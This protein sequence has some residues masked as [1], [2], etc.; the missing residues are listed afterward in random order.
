MIEALRNGTRLHCSGGRSILLL[1]EINRGGNAITY[2]AQ[3]IRIDG[4]PDPRSF[5]VKEAVPADADRFMRSDFEVVPTTK[6]D[7]DANNLLRLHR[8]ALIKEQNTGSALANVSSRVY[9]LWERLPLE[10][11]S[12]GKEKREITLKEQDR[13]VFGKID[14]LE[15]K[16]T[17]LSSIMRDQLS[18]YQTA[19]LIQK[20]LEALSDCH[21][22]HVLHGDVSPGNVFFETK[23]NPKA[24]FGEAYLT[25]FATA[26]HVNESG[27]TAPILCPSSTRRYAA[28]EFYT[29][30]PELSLSFDVYSVAALWMDMLG[31]LPDHR[32]IDTDLYLFVRSSL[33]EKIIALGGTRACI[34]IT[35]EILKKALQL[36]CSERYQTA[37]E[38]LEPVNALVDLLTPPTFKLPRNLAIS[39]NWVKGSRRQDLKALHAALDDGQNPVY[40]WG[41]GGLGKSELARKL[42]QEREERNNTPAYLI[43]YKGSMRFTIQT[44][45]LEGYSPNGKTEDEVAQEK[46]EL[47][48]KYYSHALFILDNYEVDDRIVDA[49]SDTELQKKATEEN[50]LFQQFLGSVGRVVITTRSRPTEGDFPELKELT[51]DELLKLFRSIAKNEKA[52]DEKILELIRAV[53]CHPLTVELMAAT[54]H[55]SWSP[56]S[57]SDL[58]EKGV[59]KD[60]SYPA[61]VSNKDRQDKKDR[62]SGHLKALFQLANLNEVQKRV[63]CQ[64]SLLPEGGMDAAL[65]WNCETEEEQD[66]LETLEAH[67]WLRR[68]DGLL[69]IHSLVREVVCAELNP[70]ESQCMPFL[71]CLWN[72]FQ[73]DG[74]KS[75]DKWR[76]TIQVFINAHKMFIA[77][78]ADS[79]NAYRAANIMFSCSERFNEAQALAE[80]AAAR[81]EDNGNL[82]DAADAYRLSSVLFDGLGQR[83][84]AIISA[85]RAYEIDCFKRVTVNLDDLCEDYHLLDI[86]SEQ[87]TKE[88][89]SACKAALLVSAIALYRAIP[90]LEEYLRI[91]NQLERIY[92]DPND[93][94]TV[95]PLLLNWRH[96]STIISL[97]DLLT[98]LLKLD[99]TKKGK[100]MSFSKLSFYTCLRILEYIS[101]HVNDITNAEVIKK[102]DRFLRSIHNTFC[103][104]HDDLACGYYTRIVKIRQSLF[105]DRSC[106]IELTNLG[107]EWGRIALIANSEAERKE[108]LQKHQFYALQGLKEA[109][110]KAPDEMVYPL[111]ALAN[112]SLELWAQTTDHADSDELEQL[113]AKAERYAL[114]AIDACRN[115]PNEPPSIEQMRKRFFEAGITLSERADPI[116][117]EEDEIKVLFDINDTGRDWFVK[118]VKKRMEYEKEKVLMDYSRTLMSWRV[119]EY[120]SLAPNNPDETHSTLSRLDD[121]SN[122]AIRAKRRIYEKRFIHE[123]RRIEAQSVSDDLLPYHIDH[124]N[125]RKIKWNAIRCKYCR[126]TLESSGGYATH[127]LKTC[128]CGAVGIDGGEFALIRFTRSGSAD[129]YEELSVLEP[130]EDSSNPNYEQ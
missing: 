106:A 8:D 33:S 61:V 87:G 72:A 127:G 101:I 26:K 19:V 27:K 69:R 91:N 14:N 104:L 3:E 18:F 119:H 2:S 82:V 36:D 108:A 63:M 30:N 130:M 7:A 126:E 10:A 80:Y 45:N 16:G 44:L 120:I 74:R 111:T 109:E 41:L 123:K 92:V 88:S 110:E 97:D 95:L 40:I 118:L 47:L 23:K 59:F 5:V 17:F 21:A 1:E 83:E 35:K 29:A 31:L 114:R 24:V 122:D 73:S 116:N 79:N 48:R 65:F 38:M 84:K 22:A 115:F 37:T 70:T 98:S 99:I 96:Y 9:A 107:T 121:A 28:P 42:A 15:R 68:S 34:A 93:D 67:S 85:L 6:G 89:T 128:L 117:P 51:E 4:T 58:L 62:I 55:A 75:P 53:D 25:D 56:L 77:E 112:V 105:P 12:Y 113:K 13:F 94:S 43:T 90:S 64:A 129:D 50:D 124:C 102:I 52:S 57:V 125:S 71:D 54:I 78:D 20:L 100:R 11:I 81:R 46:L 103:V 76:Q 49:S 86:V 66:A 39:P 60:S 32:D